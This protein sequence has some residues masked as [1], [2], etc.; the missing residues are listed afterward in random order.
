MK[1]AGESSYLVRLIG[2]HH[3]EKFFVHKKKLSNQVRLA[4]GR[5]RG[6][7][8]SY[9]G[10]SESNRREGVKESGALWMLPRTGAGE[11][12]N[13]SMGDEAL[14]AGVFAGCCSSAA[15]CLGGSCGEGW[16]GDAAHEGV[17]ELRQRCHGMS[18]TLATGHG[19]LAFK[20]GSLPLA[21]L[22]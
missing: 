3:R 2:G 9:L 21:L 17:G 8:Q 13:C 16:G 18:G 20:P 4:S 7:Q 6:S 22:F 11:G 1:C 10:A 15:C 19:Y 5:L 14:W 12:G